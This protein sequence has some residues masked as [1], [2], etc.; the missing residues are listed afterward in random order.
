MSYSRAC[1]CKALALGREGKLGAAVGSMLEALDY[2]PG[3]GF[4][5]EQLVA[6]KVLH[7][8]ES[9]VKRAEKKRR[10]EKKVKQRQ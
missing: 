6:L 4:V 5:F 1:H 2:D 10:K 8:E 7:R 9:R 3:C